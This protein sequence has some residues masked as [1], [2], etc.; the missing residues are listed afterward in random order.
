[1]TDPEQGTQILT[2]DGTH[3]NVQATAK[4]EASGTTM[5]VTADMNAV[6]PVKVTA[7]PKRLIR[8]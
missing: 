2:I 1:V 7:P 4:D 3:I 5:T 6:A 8:K